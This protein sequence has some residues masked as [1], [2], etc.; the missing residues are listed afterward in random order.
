M[1][2]KVPYLQQKKTT[3]NNDFN[4]GPLHATAMQV[5]RFSG[6]YAHVVTGCCLGNSRSPHGYTNQRL[7][8]RFRASD[9]ERCAARNMLILQ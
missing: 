2:N 6:L 5:L 1:M 3:I 8:I 7:Q 4:T 9:D